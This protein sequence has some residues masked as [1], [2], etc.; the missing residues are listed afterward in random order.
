M[1]RNDAQSV[2][3]SLATQRV[4]GVAGAFICRL[5]NTEAGRVAGFFDFALRY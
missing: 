1:S 4:F 2:N 5:Q 3:A